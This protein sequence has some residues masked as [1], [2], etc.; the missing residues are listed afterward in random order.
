MENPS[1]QLS[2]YENIMLMNQSVSRIYYSP[3]PLLLMV[4]LIKSYY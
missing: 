3:F 4:T 2:C 1:Y